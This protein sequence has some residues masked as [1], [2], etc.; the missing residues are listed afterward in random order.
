MRA[1]FFEAIHVQMQSMLAYLEAAFA[2]DAVLARLDFRIDEFF[3]PAALHTNQVIVMLP[4]VQL[5]YGFSGFEMVPFEQAGLLKLSQYAINRGE[6]NVHAFVHQQTINIL[7]RHVALAAMLKKLENFEPWQCCLEA[8][9]L[10]V[11]RIGHRS[12]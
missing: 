11:L 12:A 10:K 3:D 7:G 8:H 2:C 6:P 4:V 5:E 1:I 9:A